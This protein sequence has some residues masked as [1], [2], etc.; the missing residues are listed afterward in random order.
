MSELLVTQLL[1]IAAAAAAGC[2]ALWAQRLA[3]AVPAGG[4]DL[5]IA[6]ERPFLLR[7]VWP[8]VRLLAYYVGPRLTIDQRE[9][10][11]RSM[12]GAEWDHLASPQ[13]WA[14]VCLTT[15]IGAGLTA[16]VV[17][18][19]SGFAST[20]WSLGVLVIG[21]WWPARWLRARRKAI[22]LSVMRELPT[23]L[24]VL[25]LAVEAG[26]SL[27]AAIAHCVQKTSDSPLRRA[28]VR[29]LG[30]VRAGRTRAEALTH[31]EQRLALP[32][33]TSLVTALVAAD[34]SGASVGAV[35]RAQSDQRNAE[36]FA[37]AEKLAMEAP[38]KMLGPLI[39][40]I[41]PCTFIVLAFPIAMQ[42]TRQFS[43]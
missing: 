37:R 16:F 18:E 23:Y 42:L 14:A 8:V 1:G 21:Y 41:F 5:V 28:F 11:L 43:E 3:A 26:V 2:A 25:T 34:R 24:D 38:V 15:A 4:V 6:A 32:A 36:R 33:V 35:L 7:S 10:I 40:C 13:E 9:R 39:L 27:T 29:L 12:R 22:E 20:V 19:L 30:E 31:L 17:L